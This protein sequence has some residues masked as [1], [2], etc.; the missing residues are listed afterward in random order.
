MR[1][2]G[3]EIVDLFET[4]LLFKENGVEYWLPVQK[5]VIP[6]FAQEL[7]KG[8]QVTLFLIWIGAYKNAGSWDWVFLVNEF[9]A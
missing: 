2:L 7:K 1:D 6:Y 3:N 4:E 5:Q 9:E 8:D